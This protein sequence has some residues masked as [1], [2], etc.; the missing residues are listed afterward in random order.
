MDYSICNNNKNNLNSF[1]FSSIINFRKIV[2]R[3]GNGGLGGGGLE[4]RNM[5]SMLCDVR[6]FFACDCSKMSRSRGVNG[7]SGSDVRCVFT[8]GRCNVLLLVFGFVDIGPPF[9]SRSDI[10]SFANCTKFYK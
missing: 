7:I 8:S 6:R 5:L 3:S 2:Y 4:S 1:Q 10:F 9:F